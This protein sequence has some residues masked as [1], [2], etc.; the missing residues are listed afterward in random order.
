MVKILCKYL[1]RRLNFNRIETYQCVMDH[2][3]SDQKCLDETMI[4]VHRR[5]AKL[6]Q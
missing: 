3:T 1:R 4:C 6:K 2:E 5:K